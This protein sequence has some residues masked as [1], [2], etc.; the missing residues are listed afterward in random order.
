[1]THED[2]VKVWNLEGQISLDL[3]CLTRPLTEGVDFSPLSHRSSWGEMRSKSSQL[4]ITYFLVFKNKYHFPE[5]ATAMPVSWLAV[6]QGRGVTMGL[7]KHVMLVHR[8]WLLKAHKEITKNT[9]SLK[10]TDT[11]TPPTNQLSHWFTTWSTRGNQPGKVFFSLF[12]LQ[13]EV[14]PRPTK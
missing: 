1:M 11:L 6:G 2:E 3:P 9:T 5:A 8:L 13:A 10:G 12:W 14:H 4:H 7:L